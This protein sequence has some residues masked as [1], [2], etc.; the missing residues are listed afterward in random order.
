MPPEAEGIPGTK[1]RFAPARH[2]ALRPTT[3]FK[4]PDY[5]QLYGYL[6]LSPILPLAVWVLARP[7]EHPLITIYGAD[8]RH[9]WRLYPRNDAL[10]TTRCVHA[11]RAAAKAIDPR[12]MD[13]NARPG[14]AVPP[15]F[16]R[17]E[18]PLSS[19]VS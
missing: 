1:Q 12:E 5:A 9:E 17:A 13:T 14:S 15:G 19:E 4:Y 2:V 10:H 16:L 6:S 7:H 18:G 11:M 3:L 8:R